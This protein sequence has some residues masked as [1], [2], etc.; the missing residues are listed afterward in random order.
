MALSKKNGDGGAEPLSAQ[1]ILQA[2]LDE[3][4]ADGLPA[5]SMRK[6]GLR[7]GRE[8]MSLYHH[9]PSKQHLLDAMV[10]HALSS[11]ENPPVDLTPMERVR[12]AIYGYRAM[13]HR[14]PALYPLIAVHRLNTPTGV[15][16]IESILTLIQAVV[17][18]P[19]VSA[20]YFRAIGYYVTGA[21]L[22]ETSGYAK[23][24]S[25]ADP[26]SDEFVMR[27]CPRLISA[28]KFFQP[29][30]WDTTFAVGIE[31]LLSVM[32]QEAQRLNAAIS[33]P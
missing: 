5:L 17:Q 14:F 24:P 3:V 12:H 2:A 20:R 30:Q 25:A 16:F 4:A 8:A 33:A 6:V 29:S 10:D 21:G 27:E 23:G 11:L 9:F 32:G 13:A 22:D 18:D 15:C 28:G 1:R 31:A 19:E 7:L 26:V